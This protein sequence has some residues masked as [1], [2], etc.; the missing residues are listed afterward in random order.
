VRDV[1]LGSTTNP[2][3]IDATCVAN[4]VNIYASLQNHA[5]SVV[6]LFRTE[7]F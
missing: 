6:G 2:I 7:K 1:L 4:P 3:D 5:D